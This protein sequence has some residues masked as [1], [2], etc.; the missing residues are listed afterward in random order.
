M[1]SLSTEALT[2]AI[3]DELAKPDVDATT[4]TLKEIRSNVEVALK[5]DPGSL[6]SHGEF[7][8]I[9]LGELGNMQKKRERGESEGSEEASDEEN[10][11]VKKSKKRANASSKG[12]SSGVQ[13]KLKKLTQYVTAAKIG[14]GIYKGLPEAEDEKVRALSSL[15][16]ENHGAEFDGLV[17]NSKDIALVKAK[18]DKAKELEGIDMSNVIQGSSRSSR[19]KAPKSYNLDEED[20]E[21]EDKEHGGSEENASEEEEA[22][23]DDGDDESEEEYQEESDSE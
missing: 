14:P 19:N 22:E 1:D 18:T 9:V 16:K 20:E 7:K 4:A 23:L 12:S 5:L 17:P 15:L 3:R 21:D 10:Q 8:E 13:G 2:S 6:K 11:P